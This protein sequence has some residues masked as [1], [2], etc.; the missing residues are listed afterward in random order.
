[1]TM[2]RSKISSILVAHLA[3]QDRQTAIEIADTPEWRNSETLTAEVW[4]NNVQ[5]PIRVFEEMVN[6]AIETAAEDL[7]Q[8]RAQHVLTKMRALEYALEDLRLETLK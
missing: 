6:E 4:I 8:D 2:T 5:I 7:L 1:M 3:M